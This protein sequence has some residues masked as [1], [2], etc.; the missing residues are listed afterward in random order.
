[1][2]L[3]ADGQKCRHCELFHFHVHIGYLI[4]WHKHIARFAGDFIIEAGG[5]EINHLKLKGN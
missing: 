1:M 3:K 2:C 5:S 4:F